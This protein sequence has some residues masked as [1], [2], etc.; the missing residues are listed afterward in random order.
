MD[1]PRHTSL[2]A[3]ELDMADS[4]SVDAVYRIC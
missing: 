3:G 2:R 4:Y 1:H